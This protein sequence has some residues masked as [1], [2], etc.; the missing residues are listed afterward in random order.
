MRDLKLSVSAVV[1]VS[2]ILSGCSVIDQGLD[3]AGDK[4][5]ISSADRQT[6][7]KT[8]QALRSTF[9]EITDE[10]E[11]YIGRA[12]AALILARYPAYENRELTQYLNLLGTAIAWNSDRPETFAGYRF[13]VLDTDEVNALA[14]PGGFVFVSK[15]LLRLCR[16]EDMLAVLL[17][18]E[19]GHVT[20]R[21]GLQSI[22]KS[23]LVDAFKV[24]GSEV[25]RRYGPQEL[26]QL[27]DVFEDVL[28][29]I[30]ESLVERG[31]DRKYEY[32]AD[33]LAVRFAS[34]TGY[35]PLALPDL[36]QAIEDRSADSEGR[37]WYRTHPTPKQRIDRAGKHIA[38]LPEPSPAGADVRSQRFALAMKNLK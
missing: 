13:L 18:H 3:L 4:S 22:K 10:E 21:H 29:D 32:E 24:I 20:A 27:T 25:A 11:Y 8:T 1:L 37:G 15:G 26:A 38:P 30:V 31:Y 2:L 19:I 7:G 28:G 33:A 12:V 23:R 6:V 34:G 17:A 14:A 36:L 5:P 35:D 9:A 16:D